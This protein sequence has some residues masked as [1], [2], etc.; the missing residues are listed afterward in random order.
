MLQISFSSPI[1]HRESPPGIRP[2]QTLSDPRTRRLRRS[3]VTSENI[4]STE[5][6]ARKRPTENTVLLLLLL[7]LNLIEIWQIHSNPSSRQPNLLFLIKAHAGV[8]PLQQGRVSPLR[9]SILRQLL[10]FL[11]A[12]GAFLLRLWEGERERC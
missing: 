2:Y 7:P 5:C 8:V 6:T 12:D 11:D 3:S 4:Q 1:S 10:C 9:T